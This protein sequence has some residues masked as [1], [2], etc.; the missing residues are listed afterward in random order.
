MTCRTAPRKCPC[1]GYP[2]PGAPVSHRWGEGDQDQPAHFH[3]STIIRDDDDLAGA[4]AD[5]YRYIRDQQVKRREQG[6]I[7]RDDRLPVLPEWQEQLE[8]LDQIKAEGRP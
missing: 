1:W 8:K 4:S 2:V 7:P 6:L 3:S 5:K